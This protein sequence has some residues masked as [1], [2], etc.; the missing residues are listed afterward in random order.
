M[1]RLDVGLTGSAA[2]QCVDV[3]QVTNRETDPASAIFAAA[4]AVGAPGL[5]APGSHIKVLRELLEDCGYEPVQ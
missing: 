2:E 3:A 4:L 1:I 5:A